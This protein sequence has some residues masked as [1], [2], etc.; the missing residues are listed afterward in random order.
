MY[1][2]IGIENSKTFYNIG[3]LWR[4]AEN[5]GAGFIFTLGRRYKKDPSDVYRTY[6]R[7]P[8]F[9]YEDAEDLLKHIPHGCRIIGVEN[10]AG[11]LDLKSYNHL[12]RAVYLLGAEDNGLT[13][14]AVSICHE[15][16]KIPCMK[17]C[18]NVAVAGSIV[19]YDRLIKKSD[20]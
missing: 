6:Q 19:M 3:L 18:Y 1:F 2:G 10:S 7:V 5:L 20:I 17:G 4:G 16:V 9:H 11:S 8:L 13:K 15:V 12:D 14:K